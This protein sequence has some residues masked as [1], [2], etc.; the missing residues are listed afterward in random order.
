MGRNQKQTHAGGILL[1]MVPESRINYVLLRPIFVSARAPVYVYYAM[2]EAQPLSFITKIW[3]VKGNQYQQWILTKIVKKKI[4]WVKRNVDIRDR[5]CK[6]IQSKRPNRTLF[7]ECCLVHSCQSLL[8]YLTI[9]VGI[10]QSSSYNKI[11]SNS[12]SSDCVTKKKYDD[13]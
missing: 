13:F 10:F 9:S 7:R 3:K 1:L 8:R 4:W 6:I 2:R 11:I 12:L 5:W